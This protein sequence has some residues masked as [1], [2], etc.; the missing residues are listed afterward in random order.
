MKI[1]KLY[2]LIILFQLS[3]LIVILIYNKKYSILI[4]NK[5]IDQLLCCFVWY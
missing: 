1:I 5:G 2:L 4:V 3:S